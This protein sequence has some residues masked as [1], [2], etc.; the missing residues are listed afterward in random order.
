M[1]NRKAEKK[2]KIAIIGT[3]LIGCSMAGGLRAIAAEITGV[4]N[5]SGHLQEA[6][7]RGLIDRTMPMEKAV[8]HSELII[9]T[10]PVDTSIKLLGKILDNAGPQSVVI[11][12]GSVKAAVCRSIEE[13]PKRMQFVAAHPM[14]GLAVSGPDAADARLFQNR[15]VIICEHEK[16]SVSALE[17]AS[18]IFRTLGMHI[19]FMSAETHDSS[20]ARVSHLPQIMAYCLSVLAAGKTDEN[21]SL[22]SIAST[23][24][25]SS[26]R[27]ASSP[28]N[29]WIPIFQHNNEKLSA[30]LDDMIGLLSDIRNRIK[31]G[32]WESMTELIETANK[33]REAFLVE[34]REQ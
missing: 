30:S 31:N 19:V 12:A 7:S 5:N 17:T 14:A 16:S 18:M 33:M 26:T 34:S 4:D 8:K 25:E 9:V 28:A 3:G 21:E 23:G 15:K 6:L 2:M 11:D 13:H 1:D 22:I 32:H 27:L 29:M 24:F 10:V 20:V